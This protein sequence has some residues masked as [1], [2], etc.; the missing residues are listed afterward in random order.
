MTPDR[1][2]GRVSAAVTLALFGPQAPMLA[3]GSWAITQVSFRILYIG[4]TLIVVATALWLA[5]STTTRHTN[6]AGPLAM[7]SPT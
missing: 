6:T 7:H 4:T 2:Q 3:I 1:L 5:R